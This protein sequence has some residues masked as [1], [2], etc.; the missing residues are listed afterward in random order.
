MDMECRNKGALAA[1]TARSRSDRT[2]KPKYI[3]TELL[4]TKQI[5]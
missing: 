4:N 5:L 3:K 1:F 2:Y